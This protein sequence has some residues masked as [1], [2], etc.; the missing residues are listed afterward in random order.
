[1]IYIKRHCFSRNPIQVI[2]T[3][4]WK[5]TSGVVYRP[6]LVHSVS[7]PEYPVRDWS[8]TA[9]K[10]SGFVHVFQLGN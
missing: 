3:Y 4:V 6:E 7:G 8:L 1:M 2:L 10:T 5:C 9:G